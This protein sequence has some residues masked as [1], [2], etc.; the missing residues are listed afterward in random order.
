MS[1]NDHPEGEGESSEPASNET[2]L[3][4]QVSASSSKPPPSSYTNSNSGISSSTRQNPLLDPNVV[5]MTNAAATI[6]A[7]AAQ[8]VQH[9]QKSSSS[10]SPAPNSSQ[11][12]SSSLAAALKSRKPLISHGGTGGTPSGN[13][14]LAALLG[15]S[16]SQH[17]SV[18]FQAPLQPYLGFGDTLQP[19]TSSAGISSNAMTNALLPSMQSWSLE[20]LGK[21]RNGIYQNGLEKKGL[22]FDFVENCSL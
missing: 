18:P 1:Q 4:K 11:Q 7:V 5:M 16:A 13:S 20:Q 6:A 22:S 3:A 2:S 19:P 15:A 8:A 10:P 21:Y 9:M 17:G 12:Q 14:H